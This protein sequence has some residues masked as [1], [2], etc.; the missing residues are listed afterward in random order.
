MGG[1]EAGGRN[2]VVVGMRL[3]QELRK[4][5]RPLSP[6]AFPRDVSH[7]L[8]AAPTCST[9]VHLVRCFSTRSSRSTITGR[10]GDVVWTNADVTDNRPSEFE[11]GSSSPLASSLISPPRRAT[12]ERRMVIGSTHGVSCRE[13]R[14]DGR[15]SQVTF[16]DSSN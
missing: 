14:E 16:L 6:S 5:K 3:I 2:A 15:R 8:A 13:E 7:A 12:Q 1:F 11:R 4:N 9:D 10:S